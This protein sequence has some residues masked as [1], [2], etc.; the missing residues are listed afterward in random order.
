MSYLY[1]EIRQ[2]DMTQKIIKNDIFTKIASHM[3]TRPATNARVQ[4]HSSILSP[5][6]LAWADENSDDY[7]CQ[8]TEQRILAEP[9]RF[10]RL[11]LQKSHAEHSSHLS[12]SLQA[13][14]RKPSGHSSSD[15]ERPE[16]WRPSA[17]MGD[18]KDWGSMRV[19]ALRT[20]KPGW[21]RRAAS[22]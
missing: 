14:R 4:L 21:L 17:L 6:L 2:G 15:T 10:V 1:G 5:P 9:Q 19:P 20:T 12:Q 3:I 8:L 22:E 7:S 13:A 16:G 11:R 18:D